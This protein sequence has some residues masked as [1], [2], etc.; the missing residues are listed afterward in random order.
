MEHTEDSSKK[1]ALKCHRY[2]SFGAN[3]KE[4]IDDSENDVESMKMVFLFHLQFLCKERT[5]LYKEL[6]NFIGTLMTWILS[7][8]QPRNIFDTDLVFRNE[9]FSL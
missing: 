1:T 9:N 4:A 8:K 2:V 3:G 5:M 6:T 7:Y